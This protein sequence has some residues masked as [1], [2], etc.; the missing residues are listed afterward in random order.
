MVLLET[1]SLYFV[2]TIL[3][4]IGFISCGKLPWQIFLWCMVLAGDGNF[5]D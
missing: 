3:E 4:I 5:K 2:Y 1:F